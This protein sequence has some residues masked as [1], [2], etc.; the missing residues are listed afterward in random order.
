M[1]FFKSIDCM[2]IF[3]VVLRPI[4]GRF[5]ETKNQTFT[6]G[7]IFETYGDSHK[8]E[9]GGRHLRQLSVVD[10]LEQTVY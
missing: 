5:S 9:T 10:V 1:S 2:I 7:K 3:R 8:T 4:F 6:Q